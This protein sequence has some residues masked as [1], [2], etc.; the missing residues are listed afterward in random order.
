MNN[1]FLSFLFFLVLT[2]VFLYLTT[3][4]KRSPDEELI[5]HAEKSIK[6]LQADKARLQA[7][8]KQIEQKRYKDSLLF[9]V[10]L[11]RN[12]S[13]I[14]RLKRNAQKVT[15]KHYSDVQLD[16]LTDMVV[17]SPARHR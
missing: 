2:G 7:I 11:Q 1:R 10:V 13:E 17:A 14:S 8:V 5:K 4:D 9:S 12:N 15:F 16:S 6:A 3:I